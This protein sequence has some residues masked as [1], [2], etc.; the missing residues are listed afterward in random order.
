MSE[1][2]NSY[3]IIENISISDLCIKEHISLND[4]IIK[5]NDVILTPKLRSADDVMVIK[6]LRHH[7][8]KVYYP[9]E[10]F[11]IE[12]RGGLWEI[13]LMLVKDFATGL[14]ITIILDWVKNKVEKYTELRKKQSSPDLKQPTFKVRLYF[15][16]EQKYIEISGDE[17]Y[18]EKVLKSLKNE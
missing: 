8:A 13:S 10:G 1:D 3:T 5:F 16:K 14:L 6:E 18:I 7:G 11:Y 4:D 2:E 17:E 15:I 12:A 9:T